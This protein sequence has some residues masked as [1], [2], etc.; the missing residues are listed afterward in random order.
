MPTGI[1]KRTI[2][3]SKET[4]GKISLAKKGNKLSTETRLRI[5]LANKGKVRSEEIKQKMSNT[6]IKNGCGKWMIGRKQSEALK[7]KR[8]I[9]KNR[10]NYIDGRTPINHIIRNS[11]EYKL[12]RT[13]VFERDNYT[14][15]WCGARNGNGKKIIL[16]A[17][18]I[19]PFAYYPELRFSIDNGRTLCEPCH[20]TTE[21][22]GNKLWKKLIK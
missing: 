10:W 6:A 16:H 13:A 12:W 21:T 14:C 9:Y 1:Y 7:T 11:I 18:H 22:Y 15:I 2:P 5:G 19:K 20:K 17:D 3:V 8:G 4:K